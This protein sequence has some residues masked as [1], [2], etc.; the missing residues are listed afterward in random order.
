MHG[1][2]LHE[3]LLLLKSYSLPPPPPPPL[4]LQLFPQTSGGNETSGK[5]SVLPV[6]MLEFINEFTQTVTLSHVC[7]NLW[8]RLSVDIC[9]VMYGYG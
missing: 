5:L 9:T 1:I 6:E 3:L 2:C 7:R 4:L 8:A